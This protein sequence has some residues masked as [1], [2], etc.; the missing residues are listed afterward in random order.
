M[1]DY[2]AICDL[3]A[4]VKVIEERLAVDNLQQRLDMVLD[5]LKLVTAERDEARRRLQEV[6]SCRVSE[7]R[8][9]EENDGPLDSTDLFLEG[10]GISLLVNVS[11]PGKA[12]YSL[13]VDRKRQSGYISQGKA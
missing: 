1:N 13:L 3:Q 8:Q 12:T 11:A 9:G 7:L 4:R 6:V 10:R 2:Q 5:N